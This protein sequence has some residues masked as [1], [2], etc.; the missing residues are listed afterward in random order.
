MNSEIEIDKNGNKK[1]VDRARFAN[2]DEEVR[3]PNTDKSISTKPSTASENIGKKMVENRD[4]NFDI[5]KNRYSNSDPE[6]QKNL[7]EEN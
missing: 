3:E 2:H 1:V 4:K 5:A 6:N 7:E